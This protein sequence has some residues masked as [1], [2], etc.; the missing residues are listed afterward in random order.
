MI[1]ILGLRT[2]INEKGEEKK[3]D[4]FFDKNWRV[5]SVHEL[6]ANLAEHLEQIPHDHKWNLFYTLAVCGENKREFH[7]QDVLPFDVDGIDVDRR[8]EYVGVVT[9]ALGLNPKDVGIVFSGNG[10]HFLVGLQKRI[11]SAKYFKENRHHYKAVCATLD[12]KLQGAGLPG[13]L[14]TGVFDARRILRLPGTVNRKPNKPERTAELLSPY[15]KSTPF[16]IREIS[17]APHVEAVAQVDPAFFKKYAKVDAA[18]VLAGCGFLRHCREHAAEVD[19]PQ[20]YAALSIVG[21][22]EKGSEAAHELSRL[23]PKYTAAETDIKLEQALEASGPRTCDGINNLWTGCKVCPHYGK[24]ASPILIVGDGHIATENTG[25]HNVFFNKLGEVV[26][27]VANYEDLRRYYER[28]HPYKGLG[29]TRQTLAWDGKFYGHELSTTTHLQEFAQEHFKPYADNKKVQEFSKLVERTNLAPMAWFD[30]TTRGKINFQNGV[31]D[32]ATGLLTAHSP[33][34]GFRHALDFDYDEAAKAPFFEKTL[35]RIAC[36][37]KQLAQVILEY[38]GY[39]VSSDDPWAHK[40]LVFIGTGANG[41]STLVHILRG[42]AGRGNSSSFNLGD[43][44]GKTNEYNRVLLSRALFNISEETPVK[45][46]MEG[47]L[48]KNLVSGGEVF[49]R[50]I[51]KEPFFFRN[52]A[53][54][55]FLC[56]ELPH[57]D[58]HTFGFW[59]RLIIVPCN[60]TFTDKDPDFDPHIEKKLLAELPGIFNLCI[61]AYRKV[62]IARGFT[63]ADASTRALE[64]YRSDSDNLL[65][66]ARD[67]VLITDNE[68]DFSATDDLYSAYRVATEHSGVRPSTRAKFARRMTVF[69]GEAKKMQKRS[70]DGKKF[71]RG[72]CGVQFLDVDGGVNE[73]VRKLHV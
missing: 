18:A 43:L 46:T 33:D 9:S 8:A 14:D 3:Y 70:A 42:L 54:L 53:K 58:D 27:T 22:F 11:T 57:T 32:T 47:G 29:G 60:A 55:L 69:L 13:K 68:K 17:G 62:K 38:F 40:A 12:A 34:V 16:D 28:E 7:H 4:A 15:I 35:A 26:K 49:A 5:K 63:K 37:D 45:K 6:F 51:F 36:G 44:D 73:N 61:A 19:E 1:Q 72:Y 56:N 21:R 64:E 25:F 10:L 71:L 2:F 41:K 66:W 65:S 39:A 59:R 23:H 31:Y 24:V 67:K 52:R 48:F 30:D 50:N 20:W